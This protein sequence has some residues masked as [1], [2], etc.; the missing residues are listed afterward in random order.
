MDI[1]K[2]KKD[3]N[4][5][6]SKSTAE[7]MLDAHNSYLNNINDKSIGSAIKPKMGFFKIIKLIS[8]II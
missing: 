1:S 6:P 8:K 2:I 5:K 4:F 7:L 3:L